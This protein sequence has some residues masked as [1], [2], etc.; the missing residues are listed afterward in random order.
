[1]LEPNPKRRITA[2]QALLH[3]WFTKWNNCINKT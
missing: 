1:M 2:K 3:P